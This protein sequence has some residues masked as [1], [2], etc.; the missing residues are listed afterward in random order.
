MKWRSRVGVT[1][2]RPS[3]LPPLRQLALWPFGPALQTQPPGTVRIRCGFQEL[4]LF[5]RR[6]H[7]AGEAQQKK[8]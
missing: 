1:H 8:V 5:L 3:L 4:V 6:R 2:L 7:T